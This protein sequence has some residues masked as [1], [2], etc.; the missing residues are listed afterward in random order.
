MNPPQYLEEIDNLPTTFRIGIQGPPGSGKTAAALT[1]PNPIFVPFDNT[2]IKGL[3]QL[4]HLA[5][6]HP[7]QVPFHKREFITDVLKVKELRGGKVDMHLALCK[8]LQ[9]EA[10]KLTQDSTLII[11]SWTAL[12]DNIDAWLFSEPFYTKKGEE[13]FFEPWSLKIDFSKNIFTALKSLSCNVVVI[14][15]ESQ[16]RDKVT[17]ALLDKLQ[18][19]MQGKYIT[20]IKE[21]F[22]YYVRQMVR[23]KK[24]TKGIP[25]EGE[26]P[27]YLWQVVSDNKF[28]CKFIGWPERPMYVKADYKS[29]VEKSQVI[30]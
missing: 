27:E 19:V 23:Q 26:H 25:I 8:W 16:E 21:H 28:D 4:P 18:P 6:V 7:Q 20:R 30:K 29:L 5:S 13:D 11:D 3:L 12:Q 10:K 14:F 15:H 24:D 9:D 22:P 1:F 2:D 17:G